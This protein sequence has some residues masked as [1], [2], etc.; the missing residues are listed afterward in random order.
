M[1][2]VY[3]EREREAVKIAWYCTVLPLLSAGWF[4]SRGQAGK[5]RRQASNPNDTNQ[6]TRKRR[7]SERVRYE[8]VG[9]KQGGGG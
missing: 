2:G 8:G 3:E 4:T 7:R 5:L 9:S 6:Q 1:S